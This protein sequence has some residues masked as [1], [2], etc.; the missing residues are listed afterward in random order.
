MAVTTVL[1]ALNLLTLVQGAAVEFVPRASGSLDSWLATET[2]IAL[3]GVLDNI[4]S[5]GAF[6]EGADGGIVLA[7]PSKADPNCMLYPSSTSLTFRHSWENISNF[8]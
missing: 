1:V 8:V 6:T 3:Q 7:S 4:G 2:P 5:S